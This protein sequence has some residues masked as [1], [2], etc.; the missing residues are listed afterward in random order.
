MWF[1]AFM[2]RDENVCFLKERTDWNFYSKDSMMHATKKNLTWNELLLKCFPSFSKTIFNPLSNQINIEWNPLDMKILY[3]WL[4]NIFFSLFENELIEFNSDNI[5]D[6]SQSENQNFSDIVVCKFVPTFKIDQTNQNLV[7]PIFRFGLF[8]LK[9]LTNYFKKNNQTKN[10]QPFIQKFLWKMIYDFGNQLE[11]ENEHS[12]SKNQIQ[13]LDSIPYCKPILWINLENQTIIQYTHQNILVYMKNQ[14]YFNDLMS[15]YLKKNNS[16][17]CLFKTNVPCLF[18]IQLQIEN[19]I[20]T[21][22]WNMKKCF[23]DDEGKTCY[24]CATINKKNKIHSFDINQKINWLIQLIL[25]CIHQLKEYDPSNWSSDTIIQI[26]T[27]DSWVYNYLNKHVN[28]LF[29]K[30]FDN[31]SVNTM[32]K[33]KSAWVFIYWLKPFFKITHWKDMSIKIPNKKK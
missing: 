17:N 19:K 5:I 30:S 14:N 16:S 11:N 4:Y 2:K 7:F 12:N 28:A 20:N 31:K 29:G 26:Q 8:C 25:N 22:K 33:W 21:I 32:N 9:T 10:I 1:F 3:E 24:K 13:T 6:F 27:N 23:V 18:K 15:P